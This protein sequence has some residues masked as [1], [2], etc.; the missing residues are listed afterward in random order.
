MELKFYEAGAK[1]ETNGKKLPYVSKGYMNTI[2]WNTQ[3]R[4]PAVMSSSYF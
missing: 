1:D 4:L 2:L 3:T